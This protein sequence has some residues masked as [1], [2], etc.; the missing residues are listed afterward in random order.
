MRSCAHALMRCCAVRCRSVK[1]SSLCTSRSACIQHSALWPTSNWPASSLTITIS[2]SSPCAWTLPHSAPSG[3]DAGWDRGDPH[4]ADAKLIEMRLP[5][6]LI[7][8]PRLLTGRQLTDDR[9]GEVTSAH[10]V[11][12]RLVD[13]IVWMPCAQEIQEF[14]RRLLVP[15]RTR[16]NHRCRSGCRS[17]SF[18]AWRAPVSST[19]TQAAVCRAARSTSRVLI[20]GP[21]LCRL[22]STDVV[23]IRSDVRHGVAV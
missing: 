21:V 11:Q 13:D 6:S 2:R 1:V 12:R 16:R 15:C 4:C 18:A 22:A 5:G 23:E 3:G 10:I 8:E 9:P 19:E 20:E 7:G 17:R 14:N